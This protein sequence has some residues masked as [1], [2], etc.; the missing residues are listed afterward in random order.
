MLRDKLIQQRDI[1]ISA[2]HCGTVR[3]H[4]FTSWLPIFIQNQL[5]SNSSPII[6][7]IIAQIVHRHNKRFLSLRQ[8]QFCIRNKMYVSIRICRLSYQIP[9]PHQN[10]TIVIHCLCDLI[11]L[12]HGGHPLLKSG[13]QTVISR[14]SPLRIY[15]QRMI[16]DMRYFVHIYRNT[17]VFYRL[18]FCYFCRNLRILCRPFYA[19][20]LLDRAIIIIRCRQICSLFHGCCLI[21]CLR[22]SCRILRLPWSFFWCSL[23]RSLRCCFCLNVF[24][25]I[26]RLCLLILLQSSDKKEHADTQNHKQQYQ[27][28]GLDHQRTFFLFLFQFFFTE[29]FLTHYPYSFPYYNKIL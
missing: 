5:G 7:V 21:I 27:H 25:F 11:E 1:V 10:V 26:R 17:T 4:I 19:V 20:Q 18:I 2:R 16:K 28:H 14:K 6:A 22:F 9:Q 29:R 23:R 15:H 13:C 3:L 24:F 12:V 8:F